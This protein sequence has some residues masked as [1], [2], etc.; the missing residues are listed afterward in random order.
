MRNGFTL[1]ELLVVLLIVAVL[2]AVGAQSV[3]HVLDR[4]AVDRAVNELTAFY[5]GARLAAVLRGRRVRVEFS[6]DSL[7]GVYEGANDS[8]F[9]NVAGP[10]AGGVALT[11]SR[12]VIRL[13]PDG[14]GLG[15]ANT[16]LVVRRGEAADSLAIS[17]LG[18]IRRIRSN[19]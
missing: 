4:I 13:R 2:A 10:S 16:K 1:I 15:A 11:V 9:V 18:R 17:R 7:V 12:S 19:R 5:N 8:T 14:I 3:G 6:A